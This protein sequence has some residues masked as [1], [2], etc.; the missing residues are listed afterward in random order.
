MIGVS[1]A[2]LY[3]LKSGLKME[4]VLLTIGG[5][6]ARS[7]SLEYYAPKMLQGDMAPGFYVEHFVKDLKIALEE[8]ERMNIRLD[9]LKMVYELYRQLSEDGGAR[10][11]T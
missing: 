10:L 8:C 3:G 6:A 2:V 11:G 7:F 5:G 9:G 4:D 1:E